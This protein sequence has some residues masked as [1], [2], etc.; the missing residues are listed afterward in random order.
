MPI[1]RP[2]TNAEYAAWR[3]EAIPAY[4]TDKVA[5]GQWAEDAALQLSTKEYEEL[6]P[7]GLET[8]DNHLYTVLD[9]E[10]LPVGMLWFAVQTKFNARVAYV[11]D[12]SI[13]ENRQRQGHGGRAFQELEAEVQ[14]LGLAGIALH[15]FGHNTGAQAL[16]TKLGYQPTNISLYKHLGRTD[17]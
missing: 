11:F 3:V 9:E 6:L 17:A 2:M 7:Q 10:A 5:S 8:P 14:R 15:V 1:L 4:A 12:V 16:Y 13:H